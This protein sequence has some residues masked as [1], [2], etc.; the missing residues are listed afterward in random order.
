MKTH[1]TIIVE[2]M[3]DKCSK[4]KMCIDNYGINYFCPILDDFL[5]DSEINMISKRC[6]F[7]SAEELHIDLDIGLIA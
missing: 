6:P 2:N 4:C 5:E 3:P 7:N 1:R